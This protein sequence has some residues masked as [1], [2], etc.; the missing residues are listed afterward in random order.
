M[1]RKFLVPID[2]SKLE[3]QN[4]AIQNLSSDPSSPATGQIYYNTTAGRLKVKNGSAFVEIPTSGTIANADIATGAAIAY[5]KLSL[6]GSIVNADIATGAA[7][8]LS[9]LATDPLARANHTGTQLASTISDF[10]TQV[11]T[12]RLDQL[13]V[14]TSSVAFNG[15]KITGLGTPTS[16][17]DAAT[18]GYVDNAVVGIDWKPSVR[19]IALSNITLSGTQTIDG[20]SLIVGDRVLVTGQTTASQ[21]GIYLVASGSW[22]RTTDCAAGSSQNAFAVFIEEG[23]SYADTGWVL[24]NNGT[25]TIGTTDLVFTQFTGVGAIEAG[26]GLTKSGNTINAVGTTDRISV[27]ADAID[28]AS[29]YVG[30]T[31]ITT[32]GTVTTGTWSATAIAADKGG[33]GQTS[34]AVGDI[35]YA[36]TTSA[37]SKLAA[38]ATGN[39]LISGGLAT[40][41][42]WGKVGLTTHVSGT[43]PIANGGT[44]QTSAVAA[45]DA[46]SPATTLGDII[47]HNGTDNVRLA[48][49]TTTTKKFLRQ[50]GDGTNS[51]A[52]AWDTLVAADIPNLDA[53]K[54]TTGTLASARGGALRY[55]AN[56]GDGTSTSIAITHNLSTLDVVVN[57]YE[58][59]TGATVE[60]DVARTSTTVVTLGFAVAPSSNQYRVVV[61]A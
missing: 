25:V 2:L 30:Q 5:S 23:T 24:T 31:S 39:V 13:A 50:T 59:S 22:T 14:P 33:T 18:K 29:T 56:V 46:L 9:K 1:A 42:S 37:L 52:P 7:I 47:Y 27:S 55:A 26:N 38:V 3:L 10:D 8:A 51:A 17:T 15:Q 53:S 6:S 54:I 28:I 43:L 44:G 41:P 32:L 21:D 11:R 57:V 20:V 58:V 49:N 16:D 45:F 19:A 40:A 48:G 4:A 12:N 34:Y 61:V 35:L 36:S 60:C